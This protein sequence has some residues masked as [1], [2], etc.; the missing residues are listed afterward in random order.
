MLSLS[1]ADIRRVEESTL[2]IPLALL[3][4]DL[5]LVSHNRDWLAPRFL[6]ETQQSF[7]LVFQSWIVRREDLIVVVDPCNGNGR[8]R[9]SMPN[10]DN[11][12]T[13]YIERFAATGVRPEQVDFVFCTHLHCDHCG[14]N[15]TS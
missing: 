9:P 1:N 13:P 15:T 5:S 14:W 2:P 3:G 8:R 10:F 6:N 11:L 12:D 7:D 4:A